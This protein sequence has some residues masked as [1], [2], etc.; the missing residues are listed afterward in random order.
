MSSA[1]YSRRMSKYFFSCVLLY[2]S[3]R[4][5]ASAPESSCVSSVRA[6]PSVC[7]ICLSPPVSPIFAA[8]NRKSIW[9][10]SGIT[11]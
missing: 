7:S 10:T 5:S 1:L 3:H 9:G 6:I 11:S 4:V 8:A 2:V